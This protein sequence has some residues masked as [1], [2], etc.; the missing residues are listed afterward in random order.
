MIVAYLP[1]TREGNVFTGVCLSTREGVCPPLVTSSCGLCSGQYASYW[2]AFLFK[3]LKLHLDLEPLISVQKRVFQ[4]IMFC[5]PS[6]L[7]SISLLKC[8][9]KSSPKMLA[10]SEKV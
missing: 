8:H 9:F 3:L 1:A 10:G 2:N 4:K 7:V 5:H 6:E